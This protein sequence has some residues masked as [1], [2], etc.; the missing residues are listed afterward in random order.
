MAQATTPGSFN[1]TGNN[2]YL[3]SLISE[4]AW[5][6][7]Q[8][9]VVIDYYLQSG[10]DPFQFS[11]ISFG[12]SWSA[13]EEQTFAAAVAAWSEVANID[14]RETSNANNADVW[15]WQGPIFEVGALA[16]AEL[17]F[18]NLVE[19]AYMAFA[20]DAQGWTTAGLRS[21]GFGYETILHELGHVLG[22]A[23]PHDIAFNDT[24]MPG[25]SSPFFDYGD[26]DLNQSIFTL[27]SY[28]AGWQ[29][30]YP[31]HSPGN[32]IVSFGY[33]ATP[34]ALD[35][36]AVQAIYG[37][38]MT[39][40]TGNDVYALPDS[41]GP[42]TGWHAIWDAGGEDELTAEGL[43]E[44][45][46]VDLREA[47]LTGENA[48]GYVSY[49]P[50]IVG[51]FTI[52]NGVII[53]NA[54][55]GD[56]NDTI[57]GNS[58]ANLLLGNDGDDILTGYG[59][60]DTLGGGSGGSDTLDGGSGD[61]LIFASEGGDSISGGDGYDVVS[62]ADAQERVLV[63]LQI[64]VSAAGFARF[65]VLGAAAGDTYDSIEGLIGGWA[66]DNL[67][68]ASGNESL[69]GGGRSDRLYGRAGDDTLDGGI[70][71]DALYGNR[72][73][74]IMTGG[75]DDGLRDRFIYFNENET[76]V[77]AGNRDII[78]DFVSGEDRI[79]ISRIDADTTIGRKQTFDF[80]GETVF[81]GTAGELNYRYEG[82]NTII[83]GDRDGDGLA[84]LE[85]E[86][87]GIL[88]L[89]ESDFLL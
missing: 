77:G 73:V 10:F 20:Y 15:V 48:G 43:S 72:G 1:Y 21:G 40:A 5:T 86:L 34:M 3:N 81:S 70:G 19:P 35:I 61:D 66:S 14:F 52:A 11:G 44:D 57:N 22:L 80:I 27:M 60:N 46:V 12:D 50:G 71:A 17:P 8:S 24:I 85:I 79:E 13:L 37:P 41:N 54:T 84:D 88:T 67:R 63:D 6:S 62:F 51:G 82:G 7:P 36:A 28:N 39:A 29:T 89:T 31:Q 58:A 83:A 65:F 26:F 55:G 47:P 42:G 53:E 49:A 78:T 87:N 76:G 45:V 68:G 16:W 33:A 74:D 30:E 69:L 23:H 38:N 56:G 18:F 4:T 9:V 25:V 64:D 32:G 59:G 2:P 75:Q